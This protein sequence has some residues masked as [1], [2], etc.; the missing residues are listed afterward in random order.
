MGCWR[1]DYAC[2][3][4]NGA[5]K[6]DERA[7]LG[8]RVAMVELPSYPVAG[9]CAGQVTRLFALLRLA[10]LRPFAVGGTRRC[11]VHP[12]D[13]ALCVKVLRPDRTAA[14]RLADAKAGAS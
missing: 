11:Y 9:V 10:H 12:E 1:F 14:T 3:P 13:A 6:V 7:E 4:A 2:A 5:S 8:R